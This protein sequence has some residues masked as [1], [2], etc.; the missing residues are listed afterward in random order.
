ME[1]K[2]KTAGRRH[3]AG[4]RLVKVLAAL[5]AIVLMLGTA[6]CAKGQDSAPDTTAAPTTAAPV[7]DAITT[8]ATTT[9]VLTTA[10]PVT[11]PPTEATTAAPETTTEP[12]TEATT[13]APETTTQA[14]SAV[15]ATKAEIVAFFAAAVNN[16]KNNNAAGYDKVE[17][18]QI[19]DVH[20]TGNAT[21]D[22]MIKGIISGF[23]KDE[24]TAP[25][26]TAQKGTPSS[27][28]NMLGWGLADDGA[29]VSAAL[30]QT[31]G[32][33]RVTIVMAD[34]DTPDR[35]NP[36]HLEAV[37]SVTYREEVEGALAS[38]PQMNEYSDIHIIYTG[39][40]IT[41]ELTP[42]GKLVTLRHHTDIE[43]TIGRL[44]VAFFTL[45]NKSVSME[46]NVVYTGFV[47]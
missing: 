5:A 20:M 36:R 22:S 30:E 37:G 31:G 21:T 15:P 18:Q 16:V 2:E 46:N 23:A 33:Y 47:Y 43:V 45:E 9:D 4:K 29:V 11:E 10:E 39:Y 24:N 13:A 35:A 32:N 34:E 17:Y 44:K 1:N 6:S 38:V 3:T 8:D 25:H 7:T 28:E 40:T 19:H 14:P 26:V 27:G 12:L 42:D 41:A